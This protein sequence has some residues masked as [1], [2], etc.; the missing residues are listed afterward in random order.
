MTPSV[1][2]RHALLPAREPP[3]FLVSSLLRPTPPSR[4]TGLT[5]SAAGGAVGHV[6]GLALWQEVGRGREWGGVSGVSTRLPHRE[7]RSLRDLCHQKGPARQGARD[8][9][10]RETARNAA[11]SDD[12]APLHRDV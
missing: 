9:Q 11:A 10:E 3:H 2:F 4:R 5:G 6:P 1:N 7:A 8:E 12:P